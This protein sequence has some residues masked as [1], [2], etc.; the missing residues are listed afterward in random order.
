MP[1]PIITAHFSKNLNPGVV[2]RVSS[3][4]AFDPLHKFLKKNVFVAIPLMRCIIF[5]INLSAVS[6]F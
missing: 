3:K 4:S 1:P 6:N 2:L 5:K